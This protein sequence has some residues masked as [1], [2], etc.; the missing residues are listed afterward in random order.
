MAKLNENQQIVLDYFKK[1]FRETDLLVFEITE[2]IYEE[3]SGSKV[4]LANCK[5]RDTEKFQVMKALAEWG[6]SDDSNNRSNKQLN[7]H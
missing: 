5:L 3:N 6:L 4:R 7:K 2:S 1:R